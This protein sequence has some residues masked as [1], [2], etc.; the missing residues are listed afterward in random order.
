M[1]RTVHVDFS[2][3]P[4]NKID[5]KPS[6]IDWWEKPL[7]V[8]RIRTTEENEKTTLIIYFFSLSLFVFITLRMKQPASDNERTIHQSTKHSA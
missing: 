3:A 8:L 1:M 2:F 5:R 7:V 6:H 4:S